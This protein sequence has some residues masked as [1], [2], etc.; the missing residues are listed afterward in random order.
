[1]KNKE[2]IGDM[3][4]VTCEDGCVRELAI[5]DGPDEDGYIWGADKDG[6]DWYLKVEDL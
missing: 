2:I 4:T 1:M 3:I 6:K 5:V